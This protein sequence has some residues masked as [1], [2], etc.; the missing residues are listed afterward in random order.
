VSLLSSLFVT[1]KNKLHYQNRTTFFI[2][3]LCLNFCVTVINTILQ[4]RLQTILQRRLQTCSLPAIWIADLCR[5]RQLIKSWCSRR[6]SKYTVWSL[7]RVCLLVTTAHKTTRCMHSLDS[8]LPLCHRV[9]VS[10]SK[11]V[12]HVGLHSTAETAVMFSKVNSINSS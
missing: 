11:K 5:S 8:I 3:T 10:D 4:R 7:T 2:A 9:I 6:H 12:T 1:D